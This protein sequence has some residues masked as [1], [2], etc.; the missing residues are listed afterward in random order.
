MSDTKMFFR[1]KQFCFLT[2]VSYLVYFGGKIEFFIY[3]KMFLM[4]ESKHTGFPNR[5]DMI[6]NVPIGLI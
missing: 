5:G 1:N 6:L 2:F 4:N 3:I